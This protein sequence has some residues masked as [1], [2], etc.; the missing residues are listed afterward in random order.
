MAKRL[1]YLKKKAS[2]GTKM[3]LDRVG[4]SKHKPIKL[5]KFPTYKPLPTKNPNDKFLGNGQKWAKL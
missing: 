5:K 4:P 1:E 3:L 2:P